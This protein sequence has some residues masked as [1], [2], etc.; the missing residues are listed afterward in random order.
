MK[1]ELLP[2]DYNVDHQIFIHGDLRSNM[3][4]VP[5]RPVIA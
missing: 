5:C 2:Y 4:T 3:F 1:V